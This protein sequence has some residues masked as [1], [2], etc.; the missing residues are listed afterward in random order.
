[1]VRFHGRKKDT[2][3]CTLTFLLGVSTESKEAFSFSLKFL[4]IKIEEAARLSTCAF[5]GLMTCFGLKGGVAC[6]L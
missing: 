3:R 4:D 1:M 2:K 6:D 5:V